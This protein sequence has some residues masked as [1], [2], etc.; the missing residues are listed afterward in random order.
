MGWWGLREGQRNNANI[1]KWLR[2]HDLLSNGI[3]YSRERKLKSIFNFNFGF[4]PEDAITRSTELRTHGTNCSTD[5]Y[6]WD[7]GRQ[8]LPD[9]GSY[10]TPESSAVFLF[11]ADKENG[12]LKGISLAFLRLSPSMFVSSSNIHVYCGIFLEFT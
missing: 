2:K 6:M 8:S 11:L 1:V 4:Y 9:C 10:Y 5:R 3:I 7:K 12:G